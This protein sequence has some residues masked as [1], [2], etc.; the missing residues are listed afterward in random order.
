L[1]IGAAAFVAPDVGTLNLRALPA[2]ETGVVARLYADTPLTVIG[3][4]SCNGVYG[5]WRVETA[6][7]ARGWVAEG[8]WDGF[9]LI[10]ARDTQ[11]RRTPSPFAWSCES[12]RDPRR[13]PLP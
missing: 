1:Q 4:R 13:C 2:R 6:G 7:G 9:Y 11:T 8:D 10:P 12:I 3:G 5:W